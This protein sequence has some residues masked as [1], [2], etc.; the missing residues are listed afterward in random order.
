MSDETNNHNGVENGDVPEI[1]LII[2]VNINLYLGVYYNTEVLFLSKV[3]DV[4][5]YKSFFFFFKF[6]NNPKRIFFNL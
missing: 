4:N 1:E 3:T 5:I 6:N 2:K